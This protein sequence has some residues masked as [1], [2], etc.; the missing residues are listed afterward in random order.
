ML[1]FA[2]EDGFGFERYV[3]WALDVPMYFVKRG[4]IYHDVAGASFRDL[5]HGKL[6]ALPGERATLSDWKNHLSTLF[7]EV[8]LKSYLE[9][10]GA[11]GGLGAADHGAAGLLG[12]PPLRRCRARRRLAAGQGLDERPSARRSA[13]PFRGRRLKT[14][15]RNRTVLEIARDVVALA[16][17]GLRRPRPPQRA[18]A[19]TRRSIWRRSRKSSR[20]ARP[21]PKTCCA[22]TTEDWHGNIDEVFRRHAY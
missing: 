17:A 2:F 4:D 6:A 14:K 18:K 11:D 1:P 12:R 8:R 16:A 5:L 20:A 13:T 15:F 3:D 22:N 21:R 19:R 9:M 7:P 10:R